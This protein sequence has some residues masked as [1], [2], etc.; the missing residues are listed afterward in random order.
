MWTEIAKA[1]KKDSLCIVRLNNENVRK[2]IYGISKKE[3]AQIA[4]LQIPW[5]GFG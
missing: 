5:H 2:L 3:T 1:N 4:V